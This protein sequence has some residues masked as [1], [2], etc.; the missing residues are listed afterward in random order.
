MLRAHL[1]EI[2]GEDEGTSKDEIRQHIQEVGHHSA[3]RVRVPPRI[4]Q[5]AGISR[6]PSPPSP[7]GDR[8]V[9]S[10]HL[11]SGRLECRAVSRDFGC[12]VTPSRV[13][14]RDVCVC[15][16][17]RERVCVR[18]CVSVYVHVHV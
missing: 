2:D 12:S 3:A 1:Q 7:L 4:R 13:P 18:A 15:V 9:A 14:I 8:N 17:V 6:S 16:R 11:G 10:G 5:P